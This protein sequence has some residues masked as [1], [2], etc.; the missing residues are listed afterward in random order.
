[1]QKGVNVEKR[2]RNN[3][4]LDNHKAWLFLNDQN[5]RIVY[6]NTLSGRILKKIEPVFKRVKQEKKT[7][8]IGKYAVVDEAKKKRNDRQRAL[9]ADAISKADKLKKQGVPTGPEKMIM[10]TK[11][12]N[13]NFSNESTPLTVINYK[14]A[15]SFFCKAIAH[16]DWTTYG[17]TLSNEYGYDE[18]RKRFFT[19]TPRRCGKTECQKTIIVCLCLVIY[20]NYRIVVITQNK[21][22]ASAYIRELVE[23]LLR[24][25]ICKENIVTCNETLVKIKN[26]V[27]GTHVTFWAMSSNPNTVCPNSH[28]FLKYKHIHNYKKHY[29]ILHIYII[30]THNK[31]IASML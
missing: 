9:L 4:H 1:M 31:Q 5:L 29:K 3:S 28:N 2:K 26:P 22:L 8:T 24:A 10:F 27:N 11:L 7:V 21:T 20:R 16:D 13:Y 17:T 15:I 12:L 19:E 14:S 30:H 6:N 25:G 18:N 23:R